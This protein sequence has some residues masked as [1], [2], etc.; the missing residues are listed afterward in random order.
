MIKKSSNKDAGERRLFHGTT[1]RFADAICRQG[2]DFRL[3]GQKSGIPNIRHGFFVY[4]SHE[5]A[6]FRDYFRRRRRR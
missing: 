3:S 2:F 6:T 1:T 4:V 5:K